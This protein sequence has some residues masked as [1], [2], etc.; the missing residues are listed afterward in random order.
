MKRDS[1]RAEQKHRVAIIGA[2]FGG[3]AA[4]Q[5]LKDAPI[6][7]RLIDKRNYHLFQPLLYQV[8]TADVSPADIAWP[9]RSIF[10]SQRNVRVVLADVQRVDTQSRRVVCDTAHVDYDT[11]IIASGSNHS[12]FGNDH[13]AEYAPGLKSI[14]DAT[15][16][17]RRVLMAFERAEV[18]ESPDEQSRQLTFV[19]VGGG[20]TGVE[21]AGA[22]AE[23]SRVSLK[24]DF[25]RI[26]TETARVILIEAGPRVLAAFPERLS[27]IAQNALTTLG[28]EV[29]T[30][31]MV[32]DINDQGVL[33]SG[34]LCP[35]A[36]VIWAAGVQV[37]S[38][39]KWI[40][41]KTDRSGRILVQD[42]L[43]VPGKPEI[44][45]IGDAASVPWADDRTV[46]GIA[47]AAKQGGEYVARVLKARLAAQPAPDPFH[48]RHLGNLATI[49]RNAA[50]IDFGKFRVSGFLAWWIWG[51]AHIYF[52]I[53]VRRR[54]FV[55]LSWLGSYVLHAKGARLITGK[56]QSRHAP[57]DASHRE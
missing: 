14:A 28:V 10:S 12:Y 52:L 29:R 17:R 6:E 27:T 4:A 9:I 41:A 51:F 39:G 40:G 21:M 24:K 42:D 35:A 49:G 13:W 2:G 19:V 30:G 16:V 31:K 20:P 11:L 22:I 26:H 18:C 57:S 7:I 44:F 34:Q 23:L 55:V 45:V 54:L 48:Y 53:G 50:V 32:E 37:E 38:A 43:T 47:P 36:T 46:P 25:R 33:V 56:E 3:I 5:A 8:A 1:I 15:D